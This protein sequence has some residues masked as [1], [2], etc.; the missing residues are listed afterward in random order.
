M[1]PRERHTSNVAAGDDA[2]AAVLATTEWA[3]PVDSHYKFRLQMPE[4]RE[5][6]LISTDHLETRE[7]SMLE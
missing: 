7:I 4:D 6:L 1:A 5:I 2:E 3:R